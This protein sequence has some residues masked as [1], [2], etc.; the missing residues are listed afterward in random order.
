MKNRLIKRQVKS[1]TGIKGK[2]TITKYKAGTKEVIS[3][4]EVDNLVVANAGSGTDLITRRLIGDNTYSLE[5]DSAS[6]GTGTDIPSTA[7]TGLQSP[8]LADIARTKAISTPTSVTLDFFI[9]DATLANGSYSEFG[10]F[11][12]DRLFARSIIAPAFTKSTGEDT[13][14]N[15]QIILTTS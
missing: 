14:I 9:P 10:L 4:Q 8:V 1:G 11:C 6:I 7:D 5:I 2:Y 13:A 3:T 15:Y 12:G